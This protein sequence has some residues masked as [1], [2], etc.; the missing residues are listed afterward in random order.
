MKLFELNA[1]VFACVNI[2]LYT[3]YFNS[4]MVKIEKVFVYF[5]LACYDS[6]HIKMQIFSVLT[7]L[8]N[9]QATYPRQCNP[10]EIL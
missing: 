5:S 10:F 9:F 3:F 4:D 1:Y 2:N 8:F 6:T 7:T